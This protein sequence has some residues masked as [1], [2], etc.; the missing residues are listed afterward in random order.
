MVSC[1]HSP[2]FIVYRRSLLS[3]TT[4]RCTLGGMDSELVGMDSE[5]EKVGRRVALFRGNRSQQWLADAMRARGWK[6]AQATTYT[7]EQGKRPLKLVEAREL[8]AVLGVQLTDLFG[9][10]EVVL[11]QDRLR[12]QVKAVD[13]CYKAATEHLRALFAASEALQESLSSL[14]EFDLELGTDVRRAKAALEQT[15]AKAL[16]EAGKDSPHLEQ[17]RDTSWLH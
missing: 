10:T 9:G 11:E 13:E 2:E 17:G 16:S 8:A 6:W 3:T 12:A 1:E 14:S 4:N 15:P 5:E 7:V